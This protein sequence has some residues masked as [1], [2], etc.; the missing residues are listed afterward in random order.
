[1]RNMVLALVLAVAGFA[2]SR[3]VLV[4]I[5]GVRRDTFEDAYRE[6]KL[7]NLGRILGDVGKGEE[8]STSLWY[9]NATAVAPAVTMSGQASIFTG[10]IPARHGIPGNQWFDRSTDRIIDY[11]SATG[12]ACVYG[13]LLISVR[14]CSGGFANRHLNVPTIYESAT[15]AG[16]SSIAV[17]SQYWK[18]ASHSVLP[19]IAELA[20]IRGST[21]DYEKFDTFMM[22]RALEAIQRY[23]VPD[24]LTI[25]F[26]GADGIGHH[27]GTGQQGAYLSGTIDRQLGR[28]LHE[29]DR[30]DPSW[31]T[32]TL[33]IITS[34]HGRTDSEP[35][36]ADTSFDEHIQQVFTSAGYAPNQYRIVDNGGI[37]HLYVKSGATWLDPIDTTEVLNIAQRL[38]TA[39]ELNP[40]LN[41]IAVR[42]QGPGHGYS[43]LGVDSKSIRERLAEID[44][45][46]TGDILLL[47]KPGRYV[48]NVDVSGAQHGSIF[49]QDL[50]VPLVLGQGG[51]IPGRPTAPMSITVVPKIAA[52]Y[53]G[54]SLLEATGPDAS[55]PGN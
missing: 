18:G 6:G 9:E 31:A 13:F 5:D 49:S 50:S 20:F 17:F 51:I 11:F 32:H 15:A 10:V 24:L 22:D 42:L 12:A 39:S 3:V 53:I 46:R 8:F 4:D 45:V 19:S 54:F 35:S 34:D 48:G 25:Y 21:V 28:L 1:M 27:Q 14:E 26:T 7:P 52:A 16:K 37:V 30:I 55:Q 47:L 23:G 29:L 36:P 40:M 43:L 38:S 41:S 33:F 2:Q 44:T